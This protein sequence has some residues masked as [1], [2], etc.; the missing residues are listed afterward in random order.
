MKIIAVI[1]ARMGSNRLPGKMMLQL[2]K[3]PVICHVVRRV[4][5]SDMLDEVVVA[6]TEHR[7]DDILE[8]SVTNSGAS[9]YRGDE[10]DVLGRMYDSAQEHDADVAVRITGDCPLIEPEIID[11]ATNK[12]IDDN[13]E[14][15]SNT[16]NRTF[17]RGLDVE[18]FSMN[19][20]QKVNEKSQEPHQRE[21]VTPYFKNNTSDFTTAQITSDMVFDEPQFQD[22]TEIRIT[23]DESDDYKLLREIFKKFGNYD[24]PEIRNIIRYID[25]KNL[26][27]INKS[28]EQKTV[29]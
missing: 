21:H 4:G 7:R 20:F 26:D 6:T 5:W 24:T 19:S 12:L 14:Y 13:L 23:L 10:Q 29:G 3:K 1:Q 17:P 18:V 22:R 2:R 9:V 16:I 8:E 25:S 15:V 27:E 28:I 11:L